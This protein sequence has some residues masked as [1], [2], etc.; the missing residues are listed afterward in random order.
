MQFSKTIVVSVLVSAGLF[1]SAAHALSPTPNPTATAP[2]YP[3]WDSASTYTAGQRVTQNGATYEAQWWTKGDNPATAGEWGAWKIVTIVATPAPTATATATPPRA[4]PPSRPVSSITD[5]YPGT[6]TPPYGPPSWKLNQQYVV[7]NA[8]TPTEGGPMV[9]FKALVAHLSNETNQPHYVAAN[10]T[11]TYD[12]N[13]WQALKLSPAPCPTPSATPTASPTPL[14]TPTPSATPTTTP[15]VIDTMVWNS[16]TVYTAGKRATY[17]GRLYE[18]KWYTVG[19]TPSASGSW[20][21]WKDL[22]IIA[23]PSPTPAVTFPPIVGCATLWDSSKTYAAG[24]VV[25]IQRPGANSCGVV[26][27]NYG[28]LRDS[29][30]QIPDGSPTAWKQLDNGCW[31]SGCNPPT[32]TPITSASP[33]P[34]PS[35]ESMQVP[36]W[37]DGVA[38]AYSMMHDDLCAWVTDGQ[39]DF[40][41]PALK[42]RGLVASFGMITGSCGDK[43]W[44]AAKQFIADG[45]EIFSHS[46]SHTD[47]NS[48]TWDAATQIS[49]SSDDIAAHLDGYRPSF[50][51]WPSDVAADA[52]MTYLRTANGFIGGRAANRVNETGMVVYDGHGSGVNATTV[53]D[54][55]QIKDDMFTLTAQWSPYE[56]QVKAGGDLLNLHVDAA[57]ANGGWANR[58][59]H[60]VN[61][62]S[63]N[64]V[65]L[66]QYTAHLDY[67]KTKVDARL[68]WVATPSNV[69]KYSKARAACRPDLSSA[70]ITFASSDAEC[71]KFATPL[72]LK[73]AG[74][75]LDGIQAIQ[76]GK[77]VPRMLNKMI[78]VDGQAVP[79]EENFLIT[80]DPL[81]G[82]VT[83]NHI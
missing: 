62:T 57:I 13:L 4:T 41:A 63:W 50:F 34:T 81:A 19:E 45:N 53:A 70:V 17:N 10:N 83:F 15:I 33:R 22:G 73:I 75:H 23:S 47:A 37:K 21:V 12:P 64:S 48:V 78:Y 5:P 27:Y 24:S 31:L 58:T 59:M 39:I 56:T 8:V 14:T 11:V 80:V 69:L 66:A 79:Q 32:P 67:L 44:N 6:C 72:T 3:A 30:A 26:K 29:S 77:Q 52:P 28:A 61:D 82:P 76:A 49:G 38:A 68:L 46:R 43:H 35:I 65:P 9:V 16:A 2:S 42:Q 20:G 74:R 18:A 25:S 7:G 40:A 51:A 1:A 36:T 60:G 55:F 54:P 71:V